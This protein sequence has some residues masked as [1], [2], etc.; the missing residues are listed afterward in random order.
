MENFIVCAVYR[1]PQ[2][3]WDF[4]KQVAKLQKQ[5]CKFIPTRKSSYKFSK[6]KQIQTF[7]YKQHF[8]NQHQAE[9]GKRLSKSKATP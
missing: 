7:F 9:I 6:P 3:G 1:W 2:S 4:L 5:N 8:Y